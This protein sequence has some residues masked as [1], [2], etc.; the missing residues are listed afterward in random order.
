MKKELIIFG[1]DWHGLPSSTQHLVKTLADQYRVLWV[2]SIGLRQPR[3]NGHDIKRA[4]AKLFA[5]R[6]PVK[7]QTEL[8]EKL[9][10]RSFSIVN[11]RT[12][13]APRSSLVR[14]L[15]AW[16]ISLQVRRA[17]E[18]YNFSSPILWLS[19]PTATDACQYI[20]HKAI[21]YYC[22]DDFASL[23]GVDHTT[24]TQHENKL[25]EKAQLVIVSQ[26][27]LQSKWPNKPTYLLPHGVDFSL[28]SSPAPRAADLPLEGPIAGFYGSIAQWI[29]IELLVQLAQ[30]LPHWH[31]VFIGEVKTD[32]TPLQTLGNVLFLGPRQHS[33]LPSYSQ[34]WNISLLPFKQTEQIRHCNPLKLRE[35]LAAGSAVVSTRFPAA[36]AYHQYIRIADCKQGFV[37]ALKQSQ[38][39]NNAPQDQQQAVSKESWD[40][41]GQQLLQWMQTL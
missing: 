40:S 18:H 9:L 12:W 41:R 5:K 29:D 27:Q 35:Y 13:P 32:I 6:L 17:M 23:V 28:F 3:I 2:N 11:I 8:K 33:Q 38:Y 10:E 14:K 31:F 34:H 20:P 21:M 25:I 36:E 30:S 16:A 7:S 39:S 26:Q 24:V 15:C 19:L 1:E 22:C 4:W 37:S